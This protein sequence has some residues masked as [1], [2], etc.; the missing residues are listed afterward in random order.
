MSSSAHVLGALG[1][2]PASGSLPGY[3]RIHGSVGSGGINHTPDVRLVQMALNSVPGSTGGAAPPLAGD[4]IVGP[5]TIAAIRRFQQLWSSVVDGRIDPQ[6][7]TLRAL[8]ALAGL[9]AAATPAAPRAAYAAGSPPAPAPAPT[10]AELRAAARW[11]E[12]QV[13]VMPNVV[14]MILT[15][16]QLLMAARIYTGSRIVASGAPD[17]NAVRSPQRLAF[18][19]VAKHFRL[20]EVGVLPSLLALNEISNVYARCLDTIRGRTFSTPLGPRFDRLFSLTTIPPQVIGKTAIAYVGKASAAGA[21]PVPNGFSVPVGSSGQTMPEISDG[22]YLLPG[23]DAVPQLHVPVLMHELAHLCGGPTPDH[24]IVDMKFNSA[25]EY[26]AQKTAQRLRNVKCY[27]VLALEAQGGSLAAQL[28][29][30]ALGLPTTPPSC[31]MFGQLMAPA[32]IP[33]GTDPIAWPMYA[34]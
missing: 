23:Y 2:A 9:P 22:I 16:M 3:V 12:A 13:V 10:E 11:N 28:L 32:A 27:E 20:S 29:Y 30:P 17:A 19:F 1:A 15:T 6:G 8:N 33:G 5:K 21:P 25:A 31:S 7:P 24:W 14:L 4:G 34:N 26:D 18:L